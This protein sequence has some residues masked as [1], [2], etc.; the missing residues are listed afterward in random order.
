MFRR[1]PT[2]YSGLVKSQE[3][4]LFA[5]QAVDSDLGAEAREAQ[6]TRERK[7]RLN[8]FLREETDERGALATQ[9]IKAEG[10]K[11]P[12]RTRELPLA[13]PLSLEQFVAIMVRISA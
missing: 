1:S 7:R 12:E 9:K 6:A 2:A 3:T 11:P 13:K 8:P 5:V 10:V 4:D